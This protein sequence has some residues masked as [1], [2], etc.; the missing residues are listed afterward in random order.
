MVATSLAGH[1]GVGAVGYFVAVAT[2]IAG[3]ATIGMA[4]TAHRPLRVE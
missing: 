1:W 4:D 3:V 2:M